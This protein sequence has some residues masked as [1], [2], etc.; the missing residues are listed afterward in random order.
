MIISSTPLRIS[1]FGGGSDIPQYYNKKPGMVI[2]T[3]INKK[4]HIAFNRC[5]PKHIRAVYSEMEVVDHVDE[6]K[7]DRIRET[8][9][10]FGLA[11]SIE[12]CSFS[13]VSTRGT[14]LGSSS[15]FTVGLI[16]A[17][18][19]YGPVIFNKKDLAEMACYIEMKRCG[20]PIGK[21]DQY[22]AAYG[23]FNVIRFDSTGVEVAP[24]GLGSS[25]LFSLNNN[26]LC[27]STGVSRSA[28][29]ILAD[30]VN[31]ITTDNRAFDT[32]S[33]MVDLAEQALAYLKKGKIDDFGA[34]MH[35]AWTFK[36]TLSARISTPHI[37]EMYETARKAGALGGKILGAGGGGYMLLYVPRGSHNNVCEAMMGYKPFNFFFTEQGSAVTYI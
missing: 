2:S 22:A 37:D 21:Q 6:L 11:D 31:N 7:H 8:L 33:K 36:K 10:E 18:K 5:E 34:L 19:D 26:L 14:G 24:I 20:E 32:T 25:S 13:D 29:D 23:G 4:I 3:S 27:Y 16:N 17:M 35:D 15:A 9:K 28:S 30:Q 12:I 1:F